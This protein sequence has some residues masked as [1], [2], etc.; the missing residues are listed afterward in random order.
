MWWL[1]AGSSLALPQRCVGYIHAL[2]FYWHCTG[3]SSALCWLYTCS[4]FLLVL[5]WPCLFA[6][7][8]SGCYYSV[9]LHA[10]VLLA[11]LW[12]GAA[13]SPVLAVSW[14]CPCNV[15]EPGPPRLIPTAV[16]AICI[17]W[18]F[19]GTALALLWLCTLAGSTL[20]LRRL[21]AATSFFLVLCWLF[22]GAALSWLPAG[23][24]PVLPQV[25][26]FHGLTLA[27]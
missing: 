13:G 18:L 16:L 11:Q 9:G 26:V 19:T 14:Y 3:S 10:C 4:V 1:C 22:P 12:H 8:A 20:P 15:L 7:S 17:C 25:C 21:A 24:A 23:S 6:V 2:S 27:L 5:R